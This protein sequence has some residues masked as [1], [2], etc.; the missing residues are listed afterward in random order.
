MTLVSQ[1]RGS[2]PGMTIATYYFRFYLAR[3]LDHAG[4]GDRYLDLLKPWRDM[5]AMG[6]TTWAEQPEPTRS[7]AHAW[8]AHPNFDFL[9][10]IAGIR[11]KDTRDS[12]A[13]PSSLISVVL[14]CGLRSTNSTRNHRS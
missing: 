8:S 3:A 10:I 7:D 2:V 1:H 12:P 14:E 11:P 6:L 5:V 13:S 4:L 9:T